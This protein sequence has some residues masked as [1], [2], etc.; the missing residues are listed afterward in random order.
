[1]VVVVGGYGDGGSLEEGPF[2]DAAGI[3]ADEAV[4]VRASGL[5]GSIGDGAVHG[6]RGEEDDV[7]GSGLAGDGGRNVDL[8]FD[9]AF[10]IA[11][12]LEVA[13]SVRFGDQI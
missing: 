1:M 11:F 3:G 9:L 10:G 6:E 4:N 7:T 12:G 2:A 8:L 5:V 13:E